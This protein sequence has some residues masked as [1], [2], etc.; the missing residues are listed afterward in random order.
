MTKRARPGLTTGKDGSVERTMVHARVNAVV[1]RLGPEA[2][3][4]QWLEALE[5]KDAEYAAWV[6]RNVEILHLQ[7]RLGE[8]K[9]QRAL[10]RT[11]IEVTSADRADACRLLRDSQGNASLVERVAEVVERFDRALARLNTS[12]HGLDRLIAEARADITAG[13]RRESAVNCMLS[14]A[15]GRPV[16]ILALAAGEANARETRPGRRRT[17]STR[18]VASG[19]EGSDPPGRPPAPS[20]DG[21]ERLGNIL[22]RLV[23]ESARLADQWRE[24]ITQAGGR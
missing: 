14:A 6:V 5:L 3:I 1:N 18:T 21:L 2:A 22:D 16:V 11:D 20:Q 13:W 10:L 17:A 19:D 15:I 9:A 8:L 7:D 23:A 12:L 4:R 24:V